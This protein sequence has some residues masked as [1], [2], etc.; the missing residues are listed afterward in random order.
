MKRK[1]KRNIVPIVTKEEKIQRDLIQKIQKNR[2][3]NAK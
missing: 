1:L 2:I 3:S